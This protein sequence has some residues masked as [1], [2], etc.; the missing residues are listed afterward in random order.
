MSLSYYKELLVIS[1]VSS[2]DSLKASRLQG[3]WQ[4]LQWGQCKMQHTLQHLRKTPPLSNITQFHRIHTSIRTSHHQLMRAGLLRCGP[5]NI[6][7]DWQVQTKSRQESLTPR[8]RLHSSSS[9]SQGYSKLLCIPFIIPNQSKVQYLW[10][11]GGIGFW[12]L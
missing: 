9:Y 11:I 12:E 2:L 7:V 4:Q 5:Y 6:N 10:F 3:R 1:K 8:P